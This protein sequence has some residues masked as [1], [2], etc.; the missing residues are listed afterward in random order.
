MT[1]AERADKQHRQVLMGDPHGVFGDTLPSPVFDEILAD[2]PPFDERRYAPPPPDLSEIQTLVGDEV[3]LAPPP[4]RRPAKCPGCWYT[5]VTDWCGDVCANCA[6]A[7][8]TS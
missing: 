6:Q 5:P 7:G 4:R 3:I 1:L 8:V 2:D